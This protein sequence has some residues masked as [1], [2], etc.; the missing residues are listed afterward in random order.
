MPLLPSLF[1]KTLLL[2]S[3]SCL[4]ACATTASPPA[5]PPVAP[6][7]PAPVPSIDA[8]R[9]EANAAYDRKEHSLCAQRFLDAAEAEK[10]GAGRKEILIDSYY[11]AACCLA[12]QGEKARAFEALGQ[13][14][15]A[16]F[17]HVEHM[18]KD[19]DLTALQTEPGW[20]QAIAAAQANQD[21][22]LKAV[23][24]ELYQLFEQDQ[25]DRQGQIDWKLVSPRDEQRRARVA[26]ILDRAEAKVSADYFHAAMVFQ[27][28]SKPE[29]FARAH[30]L[31]SK[32]AELDPSNRQAKWLAAASKD[33]H[34]Q[35][36]GKPQIYGTQFRKGPHRKLDPG[37]AGRHRGGRR[38]AGPLER[39]AARGDPQAPGGDERPAVTVAFS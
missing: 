19:S 15:A 10:K 8:L 1:T 5:P 17:R 32:A 24:A 14:T 28:G 21:A 12:L 3:A 23:N 37:A 33:R 18:K 22:Y 13:A 36:L 39:P 11:S 29:D 38:R 35:S 25:L 30:E 6:P 7:A 31:A 4:A 20:Q 27:H 9:S 34:L 16:G 26:A 2:L